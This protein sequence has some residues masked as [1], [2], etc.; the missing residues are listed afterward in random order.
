M[1]QS[2]PMRVTQGAGESEVSTNTFSCVVTSQ[3]CRYDDQKRPPCCNLRLSKLASFTGIAD[4]Y[5]LQRAQVVEWVPTH[6]H[7]HTGP[8]ITWCGSGCQDL[9][10]DFSREAEASTVTKARLHEGGTS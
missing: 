2:G 1:E 9:V 3:P 4:M 6:F 8:Q 10:S 7:I 5:I